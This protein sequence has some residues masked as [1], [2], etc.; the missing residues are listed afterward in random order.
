MTKP[1]KK[2]VQNVGGNDSVNEIITHKYQNCSYKPVL[3]QI[4]N[5]P[6]SAGKEM[7]YHNMNISTSRIKFS[8]KPVVGRQTNNHRSTDSFY[9]IINFQERPQTKSRTSLL[10]DR[11]KSYSETLRQTVENYT[12]VE[13]KPPIRIPPGGNTTI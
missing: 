9:Y 3:K 11:R 1:S 13:R 7:I 10:E 5:K 2:Y 4:K 8:K 12:P 6:P